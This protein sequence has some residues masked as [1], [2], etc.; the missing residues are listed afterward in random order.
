MKTCSDKNC[1]I[2][3][4]QALSCFYKS[5]ERHSFGVGSRCKSCVKKHATRWNISHPEVANRAI[6]NWNDRNKDKR[7]ASVKRYAKR[8]PDRVNAR[9]A[10]Y[11]SSK[12]NAVPKWLS[13]EDHFRMSVFYTAA[14]F[15][16][17]KYKQRIEVDH[18]IPIRGKGING[19]HVPWNLQF[20]E[21]SKNMS[22]GE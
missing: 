5:S 21:R 19:L 15:F 14:R 7:L 20:L 8:H 3:T 17:W 22:K 13:E 9:T 6:K 1:L 16:S 10:K 18:I 2:K 12:K 11:Q 4:P